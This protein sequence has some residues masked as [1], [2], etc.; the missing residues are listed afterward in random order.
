MPNGLKIAQ[1]D[2]TYTDFFPLQDPPK[3]PQNWDFWFEKKPSGSTGSDGIPP[4][5]CVPR[6]SGT[7]LFQNFNSGISRQKSV[8]RFFPLVS[9]ELI[10]KK[11]NVSV[12]LANLARGSI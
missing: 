6:R 3:F 1:M 4:V 12:L 5:N 7:G 9:F 10:W 2:I 8:P 11:R